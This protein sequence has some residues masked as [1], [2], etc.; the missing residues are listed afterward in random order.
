MS[1]KAMSSAMAVP[2]RVLQ[3]NPELQSAMPAKLKAVSM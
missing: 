2:C 1:L 3:A